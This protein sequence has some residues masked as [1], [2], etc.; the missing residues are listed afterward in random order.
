[1]RHKKKS[2]KLGRSPSHRKAM[3]AALVC[4]LI[5]RKRIK[6]TI[7]KA[8]LA[9]SL[10]E[11]MV[12]LGRKGT[13]AAQRQAVATLSNKKA[14]SLLFK[15]VAPQF[16][17]RNGGYTRVIKLGTRSG[18]GSDLAILEWV[19]IAVPDKKKKKKDDSDSKKSAA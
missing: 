13:L 19:G 8:K 11:K 9:R 1:M 3:L 17:G 10:A 15:E 6:T 18:D 4:A 12:T 14:A 16:N 7:S 2:T 5:E